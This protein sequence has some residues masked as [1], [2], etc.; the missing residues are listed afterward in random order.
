MRSEITIDRDALRANLR[1]LTAG[2]GGVELWAVVKA[3]AYGH[4]AAIVSETALDEGA[5]AL[6]IATVG[7]GLELR[8]LFP[9]ARMIVLSPAHVSEHRAARAAGLEL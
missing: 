1:R 8:D 6:C 2:L 7:E 3:D 9:A 4:G 5:Q